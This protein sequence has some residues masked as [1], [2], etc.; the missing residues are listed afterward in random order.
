[1]KTTKLGKMM[2]LG[3]AMRDGGKMSDTMGLTKKDLTH[4][5]R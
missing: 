5:K 3:K 2:Q 1:M 4:K